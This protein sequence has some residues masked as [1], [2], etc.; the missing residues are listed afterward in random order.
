M[1]YRPFAA[2]SAS[3]GR[4]PTPPQA[5]YS[6]ILKVEEKLNEI[7][8]QAERLAEAIKRAN[9]LEIEKVEAEAQS[10]TRRKQKIHITVQAGI[11]GENTDSDDSEYCNTERTDPVHIEIASP[12]LRDSFTIS[13]SPVP[14][15]VPV[16]LSPSFSHP[17]PFP[18]TS[19]HPVNGS[20]NASEGFLFSPIDL[21][22]MSKS[23]IQTNGTNSLFA[24]RSNKGMHEMTV[25]SSQDRLAKWKTKLST[26][27]RI[28]KDVSE[29]PPIRRHPPQEVQQQQSEMQHRTL[30][31]QQEVVMGQGVGQGQANQQG[32]PISASQKDLSFHFHNI[33]SLQKMMNSLEAYTKNALEAPAKLLPFSGVLHH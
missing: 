5:D 27:R 26:M 4:F 22:P 23:D 18:R 25:H 16:H 31:N 15:P 19:S 3:A 32:Q 9:R 10:P 21:R 28:S 11:E 29:P 2:S 17:T 7:A 14:P 12:V 20:P 8:L 33:N 13:S 30:K 6:A 24:T 1:S